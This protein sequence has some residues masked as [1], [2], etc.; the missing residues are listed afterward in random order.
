MIQRASASVSVWATETIRHACITGILNVLHFQPATSFNNEVGGDRRVAN[1]ARPADCFFRFL[2]GGCLCFSEIFILPQRKTGKSDLAS[3]DR[4][5]G[6][7][8][9]I[10]MIIISRISLLIYWPISSSNSN[11]CVFSVEMLMLI[12]ADSAPK[13]PEHSD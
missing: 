3:R 11:I 4:L 9:N 2:C 7:T 10:I 5:E 6:C 1:F 12:S 8:R 13:Y